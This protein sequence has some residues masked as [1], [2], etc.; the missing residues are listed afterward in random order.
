MSALILV[1]W[2]IAFPVLA[3]VLGAVPVSIMVAH[4]GAGLAQTVVALLGTS[5]A[6]GWGLGLEQF[7]P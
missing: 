7:A 4:D 6:L 1:A 5:A 3:A 2:I